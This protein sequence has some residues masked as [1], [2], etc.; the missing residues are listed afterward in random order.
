MTRAVDTTRNREVSEWP[1]AEP[2]EVLYREHFARVLRLARLLLRDTEE[3]REVAQ[4]VFVKALRAYRADAPPR[5]WPA[6]LTQVTVNT[7]RD[8]R[9]AGWW[10]WWSRQRE[11]IEVAEIADPAATPDRAALGREAR[12]Q[13]WGAFEQLPRRQK[14]VFVL[15]TLDGWST[16][17]VAQILG[18]S[19]S[20]V[21]QHL[22]R[23]VRRLRGALRNVA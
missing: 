3:A 20:S 14:E 4:D 7:C 17:D 21:K 16:E 8:R 15:R 5:D 1:G 6:W 13:I 23:A 9:R 22:F 12:R 2:E 19:P 18:V 10:R 11:R